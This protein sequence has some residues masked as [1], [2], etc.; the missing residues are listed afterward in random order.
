MS[1]IA[2]P[3]SQGLSSSRP[4]EREKGAGRGETLGTRLVIALISRIDDIF[5]YTETLL[6]TRL[7]RWF[8]FA[9]SGFSTCRF[10]LPTA[11]NNRRIKQ[12]LGNN[13]TELVILLQKYC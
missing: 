3:R 2:Q 1:V 12:Y 7:F 4:L 5:Q 6:T 10:L 13:T 11:T 8:R 9:I